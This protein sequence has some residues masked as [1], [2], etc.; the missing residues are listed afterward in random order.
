MEASNSAVS[1]GNPKVEGQNHDDNQKT[2]S[3][4]L[5]EK[6]KKVLDLATNDA[7]TGWK[8]TLSGA[9]DD[10]QLLVALVVL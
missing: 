4:G 2:S 7:S 10:D 9:L 5:Q 1:Q 8:E 3:N 6:G